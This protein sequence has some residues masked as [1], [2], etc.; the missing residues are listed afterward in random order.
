MYGRQ[1]HIVFSGVETFNNGIDIATDKN[2]VVRSVFDGVVSRIFF[3][4]GAG[5]AVLINHGEYFSVYSGLKDVQVKAGEKILAK[6]KLGMVITNE[7]NVTQ[8]HFEIWRGYN[9]ENP[10]N[11]LYNAD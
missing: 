9:K 4:K 7:E 10:S 5:K 1:K 3:I 11:W 6:E 8:L 2:T